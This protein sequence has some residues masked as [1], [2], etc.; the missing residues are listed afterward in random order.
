MKNFLILL[1][2]TTSLSCFSQKKDTASYYYRRY[3]PTKNELAECGQKQKK[4]KALFDQLS[5]EAKNTDFKKLTSVIINDLKN[6]NFKG[7]VILFYVTYINTICG[8]DDDYRFNC[9]MEDNTI[10]PFYNNSSWTYTDF[11]SLSKVLNTKI[12]VPSKKKFGFSNSNR[13]FGEDMKETISRYKEF[14]TGLVRDKEVHQENKKFFYLTEKK[15]DKDLVLQTDLIYNKVLNYSYDTLYF[16][17]KNLPGY[18]VQV[19]VMINFIPISKTYEYNNGEW[20]LIDT[21]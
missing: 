3:E 21:Q 13:L 5:E 6:S 20:S 8:H 10:D 15:Q 2:F 9:V 4:N 17:F 14:K 7:E 11:I 18:K 1:F 16:E 12:I 19:T